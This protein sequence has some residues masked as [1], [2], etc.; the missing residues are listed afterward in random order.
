MTTFLSLTV[1][2]IFIQCSSDAS[3]IDA[4]NEGDSVSSENVSVAEFITNENAETIDDENIVVADTHETSDDYEWD[5]ASTN[6]I[7][8][9]GSTITTIAT[10][11]TIE[12]AIA[13][14]T[15]AGTYRITGSL[16]DGS[17]I[18]DTEDEST[19]KLIL[20]GV[21]ITSLSSSPLAIMNAKKAVVILVDGTENYL[22]DASTYIYANVDDDE[23]DA[24]LFSDDD[25]TIYG[26]G[27]LTV[28]GNYNEAIKSKDGLIIKDANITVTSVDD[29][30]Q[31]KDY[32]VIDGG[33]YNITVDGDG[34]K[35]NND[36]DATLGYIEIAAGNFS[37][38]SG[39]DAIQA[40]TF[41]IVYGGDFELNSGGGSSVSL[42][43]D[44]SAKGLKAGSKVII[45]EGTTFD[46]DAAD[47]GVHSDDQIAIYGGTFTVATGDDGVHADGELNIDGGNITITESYEG[48]EGAA[49]TINAGE[50]RLVSSDDGLNAAGDT[51]S[52]FTID[53]NGGYIF[54][55]ASGDGI[56]ANGSITMTGGA[57]IVNGPTGRGNGTL[58]FDRSFEIS[59]GFL[60]AVG[61]S[62]MLQSPDSSSSQYSLRAN[63]GSQS[64]G[65]LIHLETTDGTSLF[66]LA[67]T[68]S[69]QSVIFSA[70]S[71]TNGTSYGLYLGGSSSGMETDGLYEDGTY[72]SGTLYGSFTVSSIVTTLN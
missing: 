18:V 23:P 21:D 5:V 54:I 34:L 27:S 15:T 43:D 30:I 56:D 51:G 47:D 46:I 64:A 13:T 17:I 26:S 39:A 10:G 20:D 8:L 69:Y 33:S 12:G 42:S 36:E 61:T 50:I 67:P 48:I 65:T 41:L 63:L 1:L 28:N 44:D 45:A 11:V 29:G 14:I 32:L 59:G 35:S 24:A 66:T 4:G 68:K 2:G 60:L 57:V 25:L 9:N 31:G 40:E 72:T 19:V 49:I 52:T 7:V 71:L 55:D 22:T 38:V 37:I 62:Q 6:D 53:I 3:E 58:D 70:P 16:S